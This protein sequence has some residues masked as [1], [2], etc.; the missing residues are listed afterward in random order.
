MP[1]KP[2]FCDDDRPILSNWCSLWLRGWKLHWIWPGWRRCI[3][4]EVYVLLRLGEGEQHHQ[5]TYAFV[6]YT[7]M[8]DQICVGSMLS[9]QAAVRQAEGA[10]KAWLEGERD[11]PKKF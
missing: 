6:A 8:G 3:A 11:S 4:A 7:P 9:R 1:R 10:C 2:L 5:E